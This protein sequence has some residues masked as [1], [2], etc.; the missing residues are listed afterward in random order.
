MARLVRCFTYDE[1]WLLRAIFNLQMV[2][3]QTISWKQMWTPSTQRFED[4][5]PSFA[6]PA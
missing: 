2:T 3:V 4:P 6:I 1:R 5:S